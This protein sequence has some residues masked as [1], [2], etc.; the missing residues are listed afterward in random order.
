M[1]RSFVGEALFRMSSLLLEGGGEKP[2]F[3]RELGAAIISPPTGVNRLL[4]GERF[5]PVFPSRDP[6]IFVRFRLGATLTT[7]IDTGGLINEPKR[8]EEVL[9][10]VGLDLETPDAGCCG[11]AGSFGYRPKRTAHQAVHRVADGDRRPSGGACPHVRRGERPAVGSRGR[12]R[13]PRLPAHTTS[14]RR[15]GDAPLCRQRR[16][17]HQRAGRSAR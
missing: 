17:A 14:T 4:F 8:E 9:R 13:Q 16:R 6:A 3:W 11:M 2:G 7:H 1:P 10:K 5:R 12:G 15:G